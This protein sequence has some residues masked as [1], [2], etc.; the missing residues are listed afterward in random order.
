MSVFSEINRFVE[1]DLTISDDS[2]LD[3]DFNTLSSIVPYMKRFRY[4]NRG[5]EDTPLRFSQNTWNCISQSIINANSSSQLVL[6]SLIVN[7]YSNTELLSAAFFKCVPFIVKFDATIVDIDRFQ[8]IITVLSNTG[9]DCMTLEDLAICYKDRMVL[10]EYDEDEDCCHSG[11]LYVCAKNGVNQYFYYEKIDVS[12]LQDIVEN[13]LKI[14]PLLKNVEIC[15]P[16]RF[17]RVEFKEP[18][19]MTGKLQ[20]F[21]IDFDDFDDYDDC[22]DYDY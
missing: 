18:L 21:D 13:L 12:L 9:K 1:I 7:N 16:I 11:V 15:F 20:R 5:N 19:E 17:E 3:E 8:N 4:D 10:I 22:D 14:S 2:V 6:S